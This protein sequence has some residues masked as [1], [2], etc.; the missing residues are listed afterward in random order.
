MKNAS[1]SILFCILLLLLL[2]AIQKGEPTKEEETPKYKR[3]ISVYD[4]NTKTVTKMDLEEYVW[5]CMAREMP[6]TFDKEALKA[7]AVAV[8][9]YTVRKAAGEKAAEHFGADVCTDFAHCAAF[10]NNLNEMDKKTQN[11]YKEAAHETA[12]EILTYE[13]EAASTVFHAMSSGKTE[14]A[15]DVWGGSVPYLISVDSFEDTKVSG[16]ETKA[17]FTWEELF[18]LLEIS[19]KSVGQPKMT[20]GGSVAEITI[21]GKIFKGTEIRK[22]LK[23]RS[24]AF[25]IEETESGLSFT[26]HGYGHGVG[27]SQ[28]G[29]NAYAKQGLSYR[30]ILAKYYPKTSISHIF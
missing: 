24:A 14:N 9:S 13:G 5:R 8:R 19:E 15:A 22:R 11:I 21:G 27:M 7:Q 12:G 3:E 4:T 1:L 28:Q 2:L 17:E 23:L 26:V 6:A 30:E 25:E 29:A 10:L 16:F 18:S 20:E